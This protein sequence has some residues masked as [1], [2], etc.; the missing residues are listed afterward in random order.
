MPI[1]VLSVFYLELG[2]GHLS[3]ALDEQ[4]AGRSLDD[5]GNL[6]VW[7]DDLVRRHAG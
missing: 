5:N 4:I 1:H 7:A 3:R 2:L 6:S